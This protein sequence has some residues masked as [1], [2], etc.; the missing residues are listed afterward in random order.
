MSRAGMQQATDTKRLEHLWSGEFGVRYTDR[1]RQVNAET[2]NFH[3][4]SQV[5]GINEAA[6]QN[7]GKGKKNC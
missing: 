4:C 3:F 2:G 5:P 7:L 1:N 6:R